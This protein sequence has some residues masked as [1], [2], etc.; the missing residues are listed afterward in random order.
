MEKF[1]VIDLEKLNGEERGVTMEM[2]KDACENWGFFE[3][4]TNLSVL[5]EV[6]HLFKNFKQNIAL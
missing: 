6:C 4:L 1:P 5:Y 2:I 3:V